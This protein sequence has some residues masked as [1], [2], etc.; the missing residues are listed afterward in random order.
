[1]FNTR[2]NK[3]ESEEFVAK[4]THNINE[5][6]NEYNKL[7]DDE[8]IIAVQMIKETMLINQLLQMIGIRYF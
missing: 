5:I 7:N 8:K 3:K 2:N 6:Q 1:M 4:F